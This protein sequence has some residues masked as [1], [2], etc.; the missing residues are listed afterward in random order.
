MV[1]A[2]R[3]WNSGRI[4]P[5]EGLSASI[6]FRQGDG[7]F[8]TLRTYGGVP[9]LLRQHVVRLLEGAGLLGLKDLPDPV[10]VEE[11]VLEELRACTYKNA[12]EEC[13]VRFALF[14]DGIEWGFALSIVPWNPRLA[15]LHG[16]TLWV[17]Y[18]P[19]PHPGR[20]LI[21]PGAEVQVKWLSRGPLAHALRDAKAMGWDE[22]LL[23]NQDGDAVEGTRSNI[24]AV[25]E[26]VLFAPGMKSYA[27]PGIT[28]GVVV[29]SAT[30]IGLK[31]VDR[32]IPKRVL[33]GS[34]EI[35]LT[36]S[37]LGITRVSRIVN[38]SYSRDGI[39]TIAN[40]LMALFK[41]R[42]LKESIF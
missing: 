5:W 13:V 22:G 29:E 42:I 38:G 3:E 30:D 39:D 14:H 31:V 21:P 20:Y 15:S 41:D 12:S 17:G 24:L 1:S 19:Y 32:P 33:E 16:D 2:G 23:V 7:V 18:S 36:S 40:S 34:D 25:A 26:D 28:R 10:A 27:L 35:F 4:Y 37:L 6:G 8:E 11:K 9:F